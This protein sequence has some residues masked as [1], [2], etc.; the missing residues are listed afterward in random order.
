MRITIWSTKHQKIAQLSSYTKQ[1]TRK[2]DMQFSYC[3][4]YKCCCFYIMWWIMRICHYW[5]ND[6]YNFH[7][8][9][10]KQISTNLFLLINF[11]SWIKVRKIFF[12]LRLFTYLFPKAK[13]FLQFES[14]NSFYRLSHAYIIV[15]LIIE[16]CLF[17]LHVFL[18]KKDIAFGCWKILRSS[19]RNS[20][21][22]RVT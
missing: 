15:E 16:H 11:Y 1:S 18:R 7:L 19:Y 13:S 6:Y 10:W 5:N 17:G 4:S 21:I 3:N 8:K 9:S 14:H 22:N 20:K 12:I 2:I